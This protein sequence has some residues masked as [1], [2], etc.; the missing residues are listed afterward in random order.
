[1]HVTYRG[2]LFHCASLSCT[3]EML[4]FLQIEGKTLPVNKRI[5]TLLHCSAHV[6]ARS[7]TKRVIALPS[8]Y[9]KSQSS[10]FQ[11]P[12]TYW[13][14][15][16]E[17]VLALSP[18]WQSCC[19]ESWA[20]CHQP[21]FKGLNPFPDAP[22]PCPTDLPL[23]LPWEQVVSFLPQELVPG[24]GLRGFPHPFLLTSG[25]LLRHLPTSGLSWN[26]PSALEKTS[27][28]FPFC[29]GFF[30]G[31]LCGP[32]HAPFIRASVSLCTI[33]RAD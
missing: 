14:P 11:D 22:P 19:E 20:F 17:G 24:L 5:M 32:A 2:P 16:L 10:H 8:A 18:P 25:C 29:N 4:S 1:M 23:P 28:Q 7:G 12:Y 15:H 9:S 26:V 31:H 27:R 3:S 33:G 13:N 21:H 6:I 30:V